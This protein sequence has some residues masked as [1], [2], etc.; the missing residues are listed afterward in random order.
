MA[1]RRW[2]NVTKIVVA[3]ALVL[4]VIF[5]IVMFRAMIPPTIVAFLLA[6]IL[7][8]PVN[9]IQR[10]TGWARRTAVVVVYVLL[11]GLIAIAPV[12]FIPRAITLATSLRATFEELIT[13]LQSASTGLL[14]TFGEFDLS[15]DQ[16]LQQAGEILQNVLLGTANPFLIFRNV[17]YT[18]LTILY[19]LVLNFWLLVDLH[20]L[21]RAIYDQIPPD[22]QGDVSRLAEEL[23]QT[24]QAFLRGQILLALVVGVIA[25]VPLTIVGMPNAGGLAVL[26]GLM[27]FVPGVG[28]GISGTIGTTLALFQGSTWMRLPGGN[29]TFA[30]LVMVIY[31][32]IAQFESIYLVPKLVGGRVNLHPGVAFVGIIAG[33]LVFG[34]LGVL[35]AAPVIASARIIFLYIYR[36]LLDLE[37]FEPQRTAQTAVRIPGLIAGRKIEGIVFDLD[38]A[39]AAVDWGA[40][41]WAVSYFYWLERVA[42]AEQRR[43]IA[44]R[45]MVAME[46]IVN[47]LISQIHR[48][49]WREQP[50]VQR[51]LMVLNLIRGYPPGEKLEPLPEAVIALPKLAQQYRLALITTRSRKTVARFLECAG[52]PANLFAAVVT[53]DDVRNLLP[54][55]EGLVATAERLGLAPGQLLVVSDT[56][57]NLRAARAMEMA[58]A[59]VLSGLGEA[60]DLS[61][62]DL[63]VSSVAELDEWL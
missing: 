59:G 36:K 60:G 40:T 53:G 34:V 4:L 63:V 33:A 8:Y 47:F 20:K 32:V 41:R 19:V 3:A 39:L 7:G 13:Q 31:M 50:R 46:G 17:T 12:L 9:W 25:W 6:F 42:P 11:L 61:E 52:F 2:S 15:P 23:R 43:Q 14:V 1:S 51:L 54:H 38:G 5:L 30:L 45:L 22:Y 55:S 29:V 48:F 27:E 28:N 16:L 56:E 57:L 37:P 18:V 44:R 49:G 24:W 21:R 35:L 58:T 62:A 10:Q 26:A